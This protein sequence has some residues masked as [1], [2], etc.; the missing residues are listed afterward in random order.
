MIK[1][2]NR[3]NQH[4]YSQALNEYSFRKLYSITKDQKESLTENE[5]KFFQSEYTLQKF[6]KESTLDYRLHILSKVGLSWTLRIEEDPHTADMLE[7]S[8]KDQGQYPQKRVDVIE[9][10][11]REGV[12]VISSRDVMLL[13]HMLAQNC[14][15]HVYSVSEFSKLMVQQMKDLKQL[16]TWDSELDAVTG[17]HE[18]FNNVLLEQFNAIEYAKEALG[19]DETDIRILAALYKRRNATIKMNDIATLARAKGRKMYFRKNM[20]KLL[21]QGM[22]ICDAKDVKKLWA[23]STFFMITTKGIGKLLEFEKYVHKNTFY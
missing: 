8:A 1:M 23:N 16:T 13:S 22:A 2:A 5:L 4:V 3:K 12:C 6:C 14:T 21:D 18:T 11:S 10:T 20:Q 15:T 7:F 19:L 9:A 17:A